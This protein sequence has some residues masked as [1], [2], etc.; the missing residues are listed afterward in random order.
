MHEII[1]HK[2]V[3]FSDALGL[4]FQTKGVRMFQLPKTSSCD[5][6]QSYDF[7]FGLAKFWYQYI[8]FE[9]R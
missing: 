9:S 4:E 3:D 1:L 8:S 2:R 6:G 5:Q 7:L